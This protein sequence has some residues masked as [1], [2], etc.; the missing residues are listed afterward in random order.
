MLLGLPAA[1]K[2]E[3]GVSAGV[4]AAKPTYGLSLVLPSQ[5]Q[6]PPRAL[7]A[8][9]A[10]VDMPSM[11]RPAREVEKAQAV[12]MQEASHVYVREGA[13]KGPLDATYHGPYRVLV[14]ERKKLL[15]EICATRTWVSVDCLKLHLGVKSPV[16]AQPLSRPVC[17]SISI[18]K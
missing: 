1:P 16:V 7:Q 12:G 13:V 17:A 3:A 2:E 8:A 9:P 14:I 4:S 15:L 10:K 18:C 6:P 5:L 11:V